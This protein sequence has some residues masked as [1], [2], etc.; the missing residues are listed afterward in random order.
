MINAG[1]QRNEVDSAVNIESQIRV[2]ARAMRAAVK[3]R[4]KDCSSQKMV[5]PI[6]T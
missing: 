4:F 6:Q 3:V 2:T 5:R 1:S